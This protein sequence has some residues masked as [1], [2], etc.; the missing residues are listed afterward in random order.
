[1]G[2][3]LPGPEQ[4]GAF[5][6]AIAFVALLGAFASLGLDGIVVR[7]IVREPK[8]KY[9][10]L[11]SACI[12]KF[13][14]GVVAFLICLLV[15]IFMRPAESQ[16][17]WLVGII[18]AGIIFQSF[19]VIDLWFQSQVQSIYT[20]IAK[21]FAFIVLSMVKVVLILDNPPLIAFAWAYLAGIVIGAIGLILLYVK[22]QSFKLWHPK[23][24][25][26]LNF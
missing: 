2:R 17:Q 3:S 26:F 20:V 12:L 18:A 13:C 4:Y 21:N 15:I 23:K 9:G 24:I 14:G 5:N 6:F 25:L 1:V 7:N 16:M 10:V 11:P 19:D 8:R 22:Q